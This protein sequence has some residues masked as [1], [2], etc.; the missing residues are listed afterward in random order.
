MA[1]LTALGVS[2]SSVAAD[3]NEP[4]RPAAS[5]ARR[6]DCGTSCSGVRLALDD[7]GTGYSSLG[8]L[9]RL[10]VQ[11]IKIDRSFVRDIG[12]DPDDEAVVRAIVTMAHT[13]GKE[14]VAEGVETPAQL[15]FLRALGCD[16]AQGFLLGRPTEAANIAPLLAA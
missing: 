13:L 4:V 15:A 6:I 5:N 1:W 9:K 3:R 14:V 11:R 7:F 12:T 10:P 16:A 8:Y 2:P